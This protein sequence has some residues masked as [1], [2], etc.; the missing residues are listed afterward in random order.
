M[1]GERLMKIGELA[2]RTEM[3][4][5]TL[6]HYDETGL[7]SPT[8]RTAGNFR[9]YS[10]QDLQRLLVIRRMKPLGFTLEEMR[11]LLEAHDAL[12]RDELDPAEREELLGR[13]A[14]YAT[15]AREKVDSLR[16]Q[17]EVAQSFAATLD[18]EVAQERRPP[19]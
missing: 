13:L 18:R 10:E 15:A 7:L 2:E 3:S 6:R 16:Q 14:M 9:L 4:L 19:G 8:G 17:L 11:G 12:G 1:D 5:P